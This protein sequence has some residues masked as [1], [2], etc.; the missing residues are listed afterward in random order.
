MN[1]GSPALSPP[2][3][4]SPDDRPWHAQLRSGGISLRRPGRRQARTPAVS[5]AARADGVLLCSAPGAAPPG[6][7][8]ASVPVRPGR[9]RR[10]R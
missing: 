9:P 6:R 7:R 10:F 2:R 3:M 1:D 4:I 8:I 5:G